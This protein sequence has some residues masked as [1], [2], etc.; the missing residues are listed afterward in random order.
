MALFTS[1]PSATRLI[2]RWPHFTPKELACTCRKHCKGE[3]FHDPRFL[4]ALEAMRKEMGP[5][6]IRSAHRS[7][8]H[9]AAVGGVANFHHAKAIAADIAVTAKTRAR[10][11]QAA[12][13]AGFTGL[14][15]GRSFLHVDLGS[16]RA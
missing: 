11:L 3:Y 5:L 8:G 2:W 14:G 12:V 15:Y 1:P 13:N 9:N 7:R 10:M 4:D 16:V 6:T